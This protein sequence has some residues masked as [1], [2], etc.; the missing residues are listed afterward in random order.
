MSY[1]DSTEICFIHKYPYDIIGQVNGLVQTG[2]TGTK[3]VP[4]IV[5]T[6]R[7][8]TQPQLEFRFILPRSGLL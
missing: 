8:S 5:V 3:L 2:I 1:F 7:P 4:H 6:L